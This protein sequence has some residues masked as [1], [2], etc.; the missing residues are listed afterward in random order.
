MSKRILIIDDED[1]IREIVGLS[2]QQ[3]AG[4]QTLA[5]DSA[6]EGLARARA[7]LPDAILLDVMMPDM[8]GVAALALIKTDERIAAIPVILLTAT[9]QIARGVQAGKAA[10]V[11]L[12]P[13]DPLTLARQIGEKLGWDLPA[14]VNPDSNLSEG[15]KG[16][17]AA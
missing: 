4:W 6:S 3:M 9:V 8:D 13:F 12:K 5:A 1:D 16:V 10:G 7:E 17:F 15:A 11:I 14:A 2:L